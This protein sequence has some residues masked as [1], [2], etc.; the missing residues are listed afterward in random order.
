M[1]SK[2]RAA[3]TLVELLV[4]IAIVGILLA[5]LLPA[6]QAARETARRC[7]CRSNLRQL[8]VATTL[9]HD[10]HHRLPP[11]KAGAVHATEDH[12]S[13][14]VLLLPYLE[15]S[16][17]Y[18]TYD[19]SRPISDPVNRGV[20]T[21]AIAVY[22]CPSMLPPTA[23]PSGEGQPYGY[24]SYLISTRTSYTPFINDGAFDNVDATKPY[25]LRL[26]DITDGASKT[27]LAGEINYPFGDKERLPSVDKPAAPGQGGAF[28]WAQGYWVLAWGHMADSTPKLFNNNRQWAPSASLRT[29]RSDHPE[30][31]NFVLLDGSVQFLSTD[32]DPR[33]RRALV[34]RAGA[35]VAE[36][37]AGL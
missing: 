7:L 10:A 25:D 35:E 33:V 20:T 8:G 16:A 5:L 14:L 21:S 24:G 29:F 13:T 26:S 27:L 3:F 37:S 2:A 31:V 11:P 6:V 15:E 30:G 19:I 9:Y 28:A 1:N 17:L 4:V 32:S 23:G 36:F 34:T 22:V 18:A 12:G